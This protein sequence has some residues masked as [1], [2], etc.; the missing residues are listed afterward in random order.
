METKT[1]FKFFTIFEYEKEQ[2][3][4]RKMHQSGWKF[5]KVSGLCLYHFEKCI[6]EDA[7][8][9][10]DYNRDGIAHK[11]E[12]VKLF[13]DCGWEYLQDFVGYS[14]FRKPASQATQKEG[15]FCDESS[16]LQ[17]LERVFKGKILPL[18]AL[19]L[20]ILIPTFV[21]SLYYH[22]YFIAAVLGMISCV[23]I[24]VFTKFANQY[25]KLRHKG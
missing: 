10:L 12:Y 18:L 11:D 16:K 6:P 22:Q 24:F 7:I 25:L 19:F 4:L 20:C 14:Y 1:V 8:Y 3:Y 9:Q 5:V 21:E 15:I 23:Y 17:M 2:D 13:N